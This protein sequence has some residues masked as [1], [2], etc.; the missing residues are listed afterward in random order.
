MLDGVNTSDNSGMWGP[1]TERDSQQRR[2]QSYQDFREA[3]TRAYQQ[4]Q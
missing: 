2:Q 4:R 3:Y 1:G